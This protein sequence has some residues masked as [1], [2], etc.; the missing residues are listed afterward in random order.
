MESKAVEK[1]TRVGPGLRSTVKLEQ[2]VFDN[3][4]TFVSA[5]CI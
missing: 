5:S 3:S 4:V 2:V 1:Q